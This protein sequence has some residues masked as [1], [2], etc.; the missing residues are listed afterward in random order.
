MKKNM[1]MKMKIDY[2]ILML[3][4]LMSVTA[5]QTAHAATTID[6]SHPY[7]YG[8]NIGW[9]NA[10]GDS[11]NGTV[12][13]Q[14]F[15][16]GYL[17]SANCG[18]INLGAG[19]P[20]NGWQ[21]GNA[22]ADDWGV[23]HDGEGRLSGYAYGANIGWITF[24]QTHGQPRIDLLTG[25]LSGYVYG[26][27]VGWISLSN[28]QAFVRTE[29]LAE[30]PDSDADGIPDWWEYKTAGNLTTL[31]GGEHDAD[32]DDA[33]DADEY[34]ADTDP[35]VD[36]SLLEVAGVS[37]HGG[38]NR[39]TWATTSTRHY[40]LEASTNLITATFADIGDLL[41]PDGT[42]MS[43]ELDEPEGDKIYYRVKAIVPLS[44]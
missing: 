13:G 30:G 4:A 12:L 40:R 31:S 1:P 10:R 26:A 15:C 14:S 33:P 28:A 43:R 34:V 8:A 41:V 5:L 24:E 22:A 32:H 6:A 7:A 38:T 37:L 3:A 2:P 25:N 20:T 36:T 11:A 27:N 42:S 29:S 23:N 21:F 9:I 16:T 19:Q 44:P 35:L 39:L 17:W 18:W